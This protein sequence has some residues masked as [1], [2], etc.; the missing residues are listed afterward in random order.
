[1]RVFREEAQ[2]REGEPPCENDGS[3]RRRRL[4]DGCYVDAAL[5]YLDVSYVRVLLNSG[6]D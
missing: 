6:E 1:M 5:S 4:V 3:G 2:R